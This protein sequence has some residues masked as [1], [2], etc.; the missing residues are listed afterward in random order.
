M[1]ELTINA[2]AKINLFLDIKNRRE[3]GYHNLEMVMQ[4]IALHDTITLYKIEKGIEIETNHKKLPTGE[5]NLAYKAAQEIIKK[6]NLDEGVKIFIDKKIPIA[7]GLAGGSTD[8]AAVIKGM[9]KL[10]ELNLDKE[11][12]HSIAFNIGSDVPFC[13]EGGT[14]FATK[15]GEKL[16]YL[17]PLKK[18]NVLLIKP[19]EI[20]STKKVYTLY[21]EYNIDRKIPVKKLIQ[22]I[23]NNKKMR[24]EDGWVN[25][26]EP[27][28]KELVSDVK[29]IK[30]KLISQGLK[31]TM[32]TGSGPT[33]FSIFEDKDIDLAKNVIKN[34][35]R[36]NDFI[37]LTET[38]NFN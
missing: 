18:H 36:A 15:R 20:V 3:D 27:V 12:L 8:A 30:E 31:F 14:A 2:Y 23:E 24:I 35:P 4:T 33:V 37:T 26:L 7:A 9:N 25:V 22:I 13:L 11:E 38:K 32:M 10:F 19:P 16:R 28:T 1:K 17:N 29:V 5:D 21:D 34:W 6:V